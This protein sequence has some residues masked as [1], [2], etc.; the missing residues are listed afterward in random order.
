M[1]TSPSRL[2]VPSGSRWFYSV[3]SLSLLVVMFIGFQLF[4]LQ[5][6]S[7]PGRPITPPIRTLII[8]HGCLMTAWMLLAVVQPLL[9]GTRHKRLHMKLGVLGVGLAVG[10]LIAGVWVGIASARV[11]PPGLV[12]FGLD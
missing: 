7:F 8:V 6:R 2:R 4:Y 1:S 12:V 5:G 9:V 11:A 10:I 3:A